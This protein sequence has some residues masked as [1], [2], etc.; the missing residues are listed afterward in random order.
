MKSSALYNAGNRVVTF[1]IVPKKVT[2][3]TPSTKSGS[4]TAKWAKHTGVSG[5]EVQFKLKGTTTWQAFTT[6]GTSYKKTGLIKGKYYYVR[7]RAYKII[8]RVKYYGSFSTTKT[9]K[10]K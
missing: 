6:T 3:Y 9:V 7:V 10:C 5:Y 4:V 1:K 2:I 8:D